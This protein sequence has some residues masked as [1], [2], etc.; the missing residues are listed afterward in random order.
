LLHTP[1][2]LPSCLLPHFHP[3]PS[4]IPPPSSFDQP[5]SYL[6]WGSACC[7]ASFRVRLKP[8]LRHFAIVVKE[9]IYGLLLLLLLIS[10]EDVIAGYEASLQWALS[11][12]KRPDSLAPIDTSIHEDTAVAVTAGPFKLQR[13]TLTFTL[14]VDFASW[15]QSKGTNQ[16][17]GLRTDQCS[18]GSK[19]TSIL[20]TMVIL[21][22][23]ICQCFQITSQ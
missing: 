7:P 20:G 22:K 13:G 14:V 9:V 15:V 10:I 6:C 4:P 8:S 1:L 11:C 17:P 18:Y 21:I 12:I 3:P 2:T 5:H 23:I 16:V 19:L